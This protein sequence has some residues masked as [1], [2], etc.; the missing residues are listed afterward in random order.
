MSKDLEVVVNQQALRYKLIEGVYLCP[1]SWYY[2]DH[3][4]NAKQ[5]ERPKRKGVFSYMSKQRM[6]NTHFWSD[7]WVVDELNPLDRY[8]FLYFL[9][10]DKNNLAG[11][12]EISLRTISNETGLEKEQVQKMLTRLESRVMYVNGWI[13]LRKAIKHQNYGN[14]KIKT[15]ILSALTAAPEDVLQYMEMP[16]ELGFGDAAG[17]SLPPRYPLAGTSL[18]KSAISQPSLSHGQAKGKRKE[19]E[20]VPSSPIDDLSHSNSNI[21]SN[22]KVSPIGSPQRASSQGDDIKEVFE[23]YVDCFQ[24]GSAHIKLSE[25]RKT[26]IRMRLKD[27]GKEMLMKA[28]LN[29]SQSPFH[30]GD[31]DRGWKANIDFIIRNYEQVE[32]LAALEV[33]PIAELANAPVTNEDLART[34]G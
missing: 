30:R 33:T 31:N 29:T 21:N 13:V 26:K 15:A 20:Y 6:V 28:I 11:V 24:A 2:I 3:Y 4:H 14:I 7:P 34:L 23:Y 25:Q 27:A 17:V 12:Y 22:S 8:L 9:T 19:L 1:R 16:V 5:R 10:N 32:K 18:D